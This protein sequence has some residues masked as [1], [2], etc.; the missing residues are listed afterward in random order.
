MSDNTEYNVT[1]SVNPEDRPRSPGEKRPCLVMIQGD[2]VGQVYD[3][4]EDVTMIGRSDDVHLVISDI[5]VSRRHAMIVNR[6]GVFHIS[7]FDSTNG[8]L[9]N[10]EPVS[11]ATPLKEGDKITVGN[12]AFKFTFQDEDDTSYHEMLRNMAIEDGLTGIFNRRYFIDA[13]EKEFEYTRRN[14]SALAIVLFDID[15]FKAVN[16]AHGH[17]AGDFV[18]K[19]IADLL[20]REARGYDIF[21][22]YGGEEFAFLMRGASREAAQ[23]L[24]ERVRNTVKKATLNYEGEQLRVTISMGISFWEGKEKL[25]GPDALVQLA[26]QQ[27]YEAKRSGKDCIRVTPA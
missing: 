2:F 5:S 11:A 6:M 8:T 1:K 4:S 15:D 9:L 24:A 12:V 26:D 21:A 25:A 13:V 17:A 22:R 10:R 16:D 18:L 19:N 3:L 20:V 14:Q 23:A 7:D 27:M